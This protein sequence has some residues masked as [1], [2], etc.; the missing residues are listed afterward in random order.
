NVGGDRV[1]V[2]GLMGPGVDP[3]LYQASEGDVT[4]MMGADVIFY[5]GLHLEGKMTDIFAQMRQRN[6]RVY[7]VAEEAVAPGRRRE[8]AAFAGN[9]DP[10]V[11][12]D[13]ALWQEAARYVAR[14]LAEVDTA[15]A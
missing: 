8:S 10:H 6:A 13:V 7:A 14:T 9:Y 5:N 11:W 3:H 1:E 2:A 4:R 12:F 15:H